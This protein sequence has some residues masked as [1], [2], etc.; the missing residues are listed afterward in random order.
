MNRYANCLSKKNPTLL[1]ALVGLVGGF[2]FCLVFYDSLRIAPTDIPALTS[3]PLRDLLDLF[4][5]E[6]LP[7]VLALLLSC[8]MRH[9][10]P[11]C[12]AM[13]RR[14]FLFA[15]SS[16]HLFVCRA[17]ILISLV[18]TLLNAA[19]LLCQLGAALAVSGTMPKRA[20]AFLYFMGLVLLLCIIRLLAFTLI[21]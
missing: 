7:T 9:R 21:L 6:C 10:L 18:Y 3:A 17:P 19:T 20:F 15:L 13:T 8:A 16:A 14:A 12:L 1:F 4:S 5:R 2:L 11:L